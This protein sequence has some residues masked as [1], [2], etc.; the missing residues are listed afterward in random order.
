MA[1]FSNNISRLFEN[2]PV[3][4]VGPTG[5]PLLGGSNITDLATRSLGGL[6][7]R[8]VRG[9]PEQLTAALAQIDPKAPDAEQQQLTILAQLGTPQ[10]QIMAAQK[11][12]ANREKAEEKSL[13]ERQIDGYNSIATLARTSSSDPEF[14]NNVSKI[15]GELRLDPTKVNELIKSNTKKRET[16]VVQDKGILVDKVTGEV[17]FENKPEPASDSTKGRGSKGGP[18]SYVRVDTTDEEGNPVTQFLDPDSLEPVKTVPRTGAPTTGNKIADL[19]KI[20]LTTASEQSKIKDRAN[21]LV[22]DLQEMPET[23]LSGRFGEVEEFIKGFT[24]RQDAVTLLRVEA[25]ALRNSNAINN[26]PKGPASDKDVA[27][28]L[29]GELDP[30]ANKETLLSYARGIA[31]LAAHAEQ[32]ARDQSSWIS[33]HKGSLNGFSDWQ[34]V[35]RYEKEFINL[36]DPVF[37]AEKGIPAE[38]LRM[39]EEN[40]DD[41]LLGMQFNET[42]KYDYAEALKNNKRSKELLEATGRNM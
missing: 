19:Q 1:L 24:G 31:K 40:P 21:K 17:I 39:I 2:N 16:T 35:K 10:Q 36:K 29:A 22:N 15:A 41:V 3:N 38:A 42:Y 37:L 26:L 27:L 33:K 6:L 12:K 14:L 13:A 32:N 11:I 20:V 9:R 5:Q 25:T 8:E 7:G 34:Q 18:A 23:Y 4:Q 30:Y 28:V